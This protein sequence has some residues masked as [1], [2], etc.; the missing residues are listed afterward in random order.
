MGA[1]CTDKLDQTAAFQPDCT[2]KRKYATTTFFLT[3]EKKKCRVC[4]VKSN[5][6]GQCRD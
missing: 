1:E 4:E 3:K 2:E 6:F 5:I